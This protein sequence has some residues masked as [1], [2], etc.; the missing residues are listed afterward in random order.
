MISPQP[1]NNLRNAKEYFREHLAVGDY[2][3]VK[4]AEY[5]TQENTVIGERFG[6]GATRLNLTGNIAESAF[7]AWC[8][9][10]DPAI[11]ERLT[12]RRN[13]VRRKGA[14]VVANRR[15][16][17]A[18]PF[19]RRKAFRWWRSC[20]IAGSLKRIRGPFRPR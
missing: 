19:A 20:R 11:G 14:S 3:A 5:F 9:S 13:S 10:N 15:I 17:Y 1:Q 8:E 18:G 12:A 16:F 2:C 7:L 6:A 4:N